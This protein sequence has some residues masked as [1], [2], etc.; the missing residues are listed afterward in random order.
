MFTQRIREFQRIACKWHEKKIWIMRLCLFTSGKFVIFMWYGSKKVRPKSGP[1]KN[2]W[3]CDTENDPTTSKRK[4]K[5]AFK[6]QYE[7][8]DLKYGIITVADSHTLYNTPCL[9]KWSQMNETLKLLSPPPTKKTHRIVCLRFLDPVQYF[10][11]GVFIVSHYPQDGARWREAS[12]VLPLITTITF[13]VMV[14]CNVD[15]L[16]LRRPI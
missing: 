15:D 11:S 7:Q 13:G 8:S 12:T 3:I 4:K 10:W 2:G 1:K 6:R 9:A 16:F 5:A 14:H